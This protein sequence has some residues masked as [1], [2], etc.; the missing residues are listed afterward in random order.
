MAKRIFYT[1]LGALLALALGLTKPL[2]AAEK[3]YYF[4]EVRI[5]VAASG[6]RPCRRVPHLRVRGRFH[7]GDALVPSLHDA[8]GNDLQHGHRRFPGPRRGWP[9]SA[10]YY[11]GQEQ[12]IHSPL[13]LSGP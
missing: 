1:G 5:E 7:L 11:S 13:E 8:P 9:L 10:R 4:P 2:S 3:D 12:S 6:V